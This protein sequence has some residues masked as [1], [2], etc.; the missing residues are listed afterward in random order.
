M[1]LGEVVGVDPVQHPPRGRHRGH[2]PEQLLPVT[3]HTDAADRVS[4]IGDRDREIGEHP[5]RRVHRDTPVGIQQ[6]LGDRVDQ[7]GVLGHLPE[8]TDPGMRHHTVAVRADND[9]TYLLA[10]LHLRSARSVSDS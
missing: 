4:T 6:R 2:R 10:T 1:H 7:P 5:T 3:Q 9:S 8:Q